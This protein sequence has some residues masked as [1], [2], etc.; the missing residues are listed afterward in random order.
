MSDALVSALLYGQRRRTDPHDAKRRYGLGVMQQA[1]TPSQS[2]G[3]GLAKMLQAGVGGYFAG[4]ANRESDERSR[5]TTDA[6]AKALGASDTAS[7]TAALKEGGADSDVLGPI[8][9]QLLSQRFSDERKAQLGQRSYQA[10]GGGGSVMMPPPPPGGAIASQPLPATPMAPGGFANNAGNIRASGAAWEGKGPPQNGFET[11]NSPQAGANAMFKNLGAYAQQNPS[12]TVAQAIAKW[13]PPN[14]NDTQGY[15][16]RLAEAT[17]I[18]PGMPL[19][20]VLKD[21]AVAATLMDGITRIE[22]GGM[23]QGFSADT[24]MQASSPPP[25]QGPQPVAQGDAGQPPQQQA[26]RPSF[27]PGADYEAL[28]QR[29]AQSGD[30]ETATKYQ[31]EANKARSQFKLDEYKDTTKRAAD[32]PQRNVDNEGKMRGDF[33]GLQSIKDYRKAA[34]V[35]RSAVDASKV[36]SAAADLNM[37]YAFATLMDPG[38]VVRES[39]SGMVIAT[40]NASDRVKALVASVSGGQR[41]SPEARSA[42]LNEMASRY[43][44]YRVA[45]DDL[46]KTYGD[47]AT[48]SGADPRNVVVPYPRVEY[49]RKAPRQGPPKAG[50]VLDGWRFKGGDPSQQQNWEQV[51]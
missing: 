33:E 21:P 14:E 5:K 29:A 31:M 19:G 45:H 6:L 12:M 47:I 4:E 8:M 7:A 25:M 15:V 48:R 32:Q 36:N 43:D 23:P 39:E 1:M 26:P 2:W 3:E 44:A 28:G 13:A 10:A 38:S 34:T 37:V 49:E 41:I 9:G 42:L 46:G 18:N 35:F 22:K 20:E 24:F 50:E 40:Q 16:T 11:F 17:G 51:Q 30:Y 27:D